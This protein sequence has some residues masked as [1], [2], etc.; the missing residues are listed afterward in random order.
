MSKII[1]NIIIATSILGIFPAI[2][3]NY[4]N[5][6]ITKVY[7]EEVSEKEEDKPHLKRIYLTEGDNFK[8]SDDVHSYLVDVDKDTDET[9]VVAKPED[10]KYIVRIDGQIVTDDDHY[11]KEVKL[12]KG[13]NKIKVEVEDDKTQSKSE[14]IVNVFRGGKNAVYLND[15][16]IDGNTIGFD[17]S[18][19]YYNIELDDNSNIIELDTIPEDDAYSITVNGKELGDKNSIKIKF[20]KGI[21][22]YTLNIGIKDKDTDRVG[23]YT[24]NIYLGIPV[25]PNVTEAIKSVI[26]PNQWVMENGRWRYNDVMGNYLKDTWYYDDKYKS[27]FHF[28]KIGNMQ[29]NWLKDGDNWYYLNQRGEMQTGWL[30]YENE[31]YFLDSNGVMRTGWILYDNNWY[32]FRKNGTMAT[33]WIMDKDKWY[34]INSKGVMWT[35][36]LYYG[37]KWYHL[38]ESGAM[39][40]GWLQYCDEWYFLKPDGSMKSGEWLY[41]DGNWYYIT[42]AGSMIHGK[43][44]EKDNK[45]YY[46]NQDGTMQ[47]VPMILDGYAYD[48]NEDGSANFS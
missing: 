13:K 21:G 17:K 19:N 37:K 26:K 32:Y 43:W 15:I 28:N 6:N 39:Q 7:A 20:T 33:G 40:T 47:T 44:L 11:M 9:F 48:F 10:P 38:D 45:D 35:G 42:Y 8:F 22:K 30:Y 3:P 25:T 29:T 2:Q 12:D 4:L 41:S 23:N 31:W 5:L 34:Y 1:R 27:Y 18:S 16:N 14:Y 46:F 24:L 36:W